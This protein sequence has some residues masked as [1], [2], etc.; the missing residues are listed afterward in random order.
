MTAVSPDPIR[1]PSSGAGATPHQRRLGAGAL[2]YDEGDP[3]GEIFLVRAGEVELARRGAGGTR[4]VSRVGP[5]E[6]FGEHGTLL[7]GPRPGRATVTRE[8]ELLALDPDTFET[9]C[10]ERPEIGLRFA[11]ALAARAQALEQRL[12]SLEAEDG[13][14]AIVRVLQRLARHEEG[15]TR[16]EAPLRRLAAEAGLGLLDAHHAVQR[17]VERKRVRLVDDALVIPDPELL[18]ASADP[19]ASPEKPLSR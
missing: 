1:D 18:A 15:T 19:V 10:L 13:L 6:F 5:G 12:V 9:M 4:A 2:V 17:L 14:R 11:R 3:G 7:P 16:V 8:A